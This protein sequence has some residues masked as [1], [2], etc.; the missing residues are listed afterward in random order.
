MS[1]ADSLRW[2]LTL[3]PWTWVARWLLFQQLP[4]NHPPLNLGRPLAN[5]T[6]LHVA[7][8]LSDQQMAFDPGR[9]TPYDK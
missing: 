5:R 6:L 9:R 8:I 3:R 7:V 4:H 2:V 1:S